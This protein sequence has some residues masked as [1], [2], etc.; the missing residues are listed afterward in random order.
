MIQEPNRPIVAFI[1]KQSIKDEQTVV[2]SKWPRSSASPSFKIALVTEGCFQALSQAES[3]RRNSVH[4]SGSR[5]SPSISIADA[6]ILGKKRRLAEHLCG[7]KSPLWLTPGSKLIYLVRLLQMS[8]Y[9]RDFFSNYL[10]HSTRYYPS[11]RLLSRYEQISLFAICFIALLIQCLSMDRWT[12]SLQREKN[13]I[14]SEPANC[15]NV[16]H[17]ASHVASI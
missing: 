3:R 17:C 4:E 16:N 12:G 14:A 10:M 2:S 11:D 5:S 9:C 8:L 7:G 13:K 1:Q 6:L 15:Q